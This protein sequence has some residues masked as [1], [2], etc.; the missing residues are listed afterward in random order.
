MDAAM[1]SRHLAAGEMYGRDSTCGT[2]IKHDTEEAARTAADALNRKGKARHVVEAY[3]CFW[4]G[5]WHIGRAMEANEFA[6]VD[7]WVSTGK[8]QSPLV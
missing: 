7:L 6:L 1:A 3:P 5:S 4:C 2:K 8:P